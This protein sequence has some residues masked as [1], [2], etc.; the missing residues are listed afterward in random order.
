MRTTAVMNTSAPTT[1]PAIAPAFVFPLLLLLPDEEEA[2]EVAV[3][4]ADIEDVLV[5]LGR[6]VDSGESPMDSAKVTLKEGLV[7]TF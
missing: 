3:D 1:P 6:A 5:E 2:V 7:V 4:G